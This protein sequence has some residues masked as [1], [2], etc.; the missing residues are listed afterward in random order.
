MKNTEWI[1]QVSKLAGL[2]YYPD[3]RIFG[4]RS[5]AVIGI[6]DG[7]IVAIGLGKVNGKNAAV[8]MLLRYT[9]AQDAGRI[10]QALDP[11]KGKFKLAAVDATTAT[12]VRTYSFGKPDAS[13][14]A[15]DLRNL[16]ATLKTSASPINRKCEECGKAEPQIILLNDVPT[17]YCPGCQVQ[18]SQKLDAAAIA[19]ENLETNLPLGLL[20]GAAAALLG[21][22]A[23][24]GVAYGLNRIFLWGA[25]GI[26]L[27]V[28]KAVVKGTGKVTWTARIMIGV[29]TAASVAFGDAIFY[30]LVIMKQH[31]LAFMPVLKI[32]VQ[33]FWKLE[34]DSEGGLVS[35][36]FGLIG[37]GITVYGTRKPAFKARFVTLG[38]PASTLRNAAAN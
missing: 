7:Y 36:L 8:K 3:H 15:D 18:L 25:I 28:G 21:S 35:I 4:D 19:Y 2:P 1:A 6:S 13:A 38:T 10:K 31:Q 20:Y 37:A 11:A 34:S 27:L 14:I 16:V 9:K 30:A 17:H 12:L 24:G 29:L 23:W 5:G 22:I 26:G 32:V 33:N